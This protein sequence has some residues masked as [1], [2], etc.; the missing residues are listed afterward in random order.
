MRTEDEFYCTLKLVTGEE[1]FALIMVDDSVEDPILILQEPV[2]ISMKQQG[3]YS[4]IKIE[5]WMKTTRDDI[6][7]VKLSHVVTMT[8]ADDPE[9]VDFYKDFLDQKAEWE[10]AME[11]DEYEESTPQRGDLNKKMGFLGSVEES[12]KSL[13]DVFKLDYKDKDIKDS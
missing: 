5:P 10:D 7:F 11:E 12:K 13:E 8:E 1:I 9:M 4:N 6:F 2:V 3:A